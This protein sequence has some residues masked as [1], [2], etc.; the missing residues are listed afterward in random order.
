MYLYSNFKSNKFQ[1][2]TNLFIFY[3]SFYGLISI[4]SNNQLFIFL[5]EILAVIIVSYSLITIILMAKLPRVYVEL[6][7]LF[8]VIFFISLVGIIGNENIINIAY[9]M[10][11]T[12]LPLSFLFVGNLFNFSYSY[13]GKKHLFFLFLIYVSLIFVW[14]RQYLTGIEVLILKGYEYGTNLKH[15]DGYPRLP[16]ISGTPDSYAFFLA[17]TSLI[18]VNELRKYKKNKLSYLLT[19]ITFLFLSL[20]T[21]RSA[22]IFFIIV[23]ISLFIYTV[24]NLHKEKFLFRL[25]TIFTVSALSIPIIFINFLDSKIFDMYSIFDRISHWF[26]N[27]PI[28][29][30][31]EFWFGKGLGAVG[32]ASKSV[33]KLGYESLNY[34]VDNQFLSIFIQIGMVGLFAFLAMLFKVYS[35]LRKFLYNFNISEP[36]RYDVHLSIALLNGLFISSIFTNV[37]ELY[38]FNVL[39]F[40]FL[41]TTLYSLIK[42]E[43]NR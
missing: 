20:A 2:L 11:I 10:K 5:K 37:I 40:G 33:F 12:L 42:F 38:P 6:L 14:T 26:T 22:I 8:S 9:G 32:S 43:S 18:L 17:I 19:I 27:I 39:F 13:M 21:I 24:S 1:I 4:Y 36:N 3:I 23:H 35:F 41:G 7:Y 29:S 16:S 28:F 34:P 25:I 15:I 30:S 31:C